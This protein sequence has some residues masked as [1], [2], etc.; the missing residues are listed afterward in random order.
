MGHVHTDENLA[1]PLTKGIAKRKS[2]IQRWDYNAYELLMME[3]QPKR[4]EIPRIR[5]NG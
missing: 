5:F 1:D 3:T 2:I 4:L